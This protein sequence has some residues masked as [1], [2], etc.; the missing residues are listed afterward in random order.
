MTF[1]KLP[2]EFPV[3]EAGG[4]VLRR[5]EQDDASNWYAYLTDPAVTEFTSG[6][7]E[8]REEMNQAVLEF[9]AQ[10]EAKER[11]RW[12]IARNDDNRMVGDCGY[13]RLDGRNRSGVI[14]YQLSPEHW[15]R[16]IMTR[17][18]TEI[19]RYGFEALDLNRIEATVRP[20]NGRSIRVLQKLGFQQEG[21][22]RDY[23]FSRGASFDCFIF[24]LLR[25]EWR[26]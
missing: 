24:S 13:N 16:G 23:R 6:D 8:G 21:L 19:V 15:G 26:P 4:F 10:F 1:P 20:G 11:I 17:A 2:D 14:G 18:V 9:Q 22:L 3:L 5:I 25:R 12:A 7:V